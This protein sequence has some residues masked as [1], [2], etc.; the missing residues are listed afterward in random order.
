MS[1]TPQSSRHGKRKDGIVVMTFPVPEKLKR[2]IR[3]LAYAEG[4]TVSEW[5]RIQCEAICRREK[6]LG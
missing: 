4:H 2:N 6:S 1:D 5:L 3:R